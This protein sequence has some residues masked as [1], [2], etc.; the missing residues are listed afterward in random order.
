[1]AHTIG[2][3][4]LT[5]ALC[6]CLAA[7]GV[8]AVLLGQHY[9]EPWAVSAVDA[10]CG[11][12]SQSGCE[13]VA[14]SA[15][16][17]VGGIPLAALGTA[18]YLSLCILLL[19]ILFAPPDLRDVLGGLALIMLVFGLVVDLLLLG[20]QAFSIRAY[21]ILCITTYVLA[22]GALIALLPA[23][24]S[25]HG[26]V[27]APRRP[28]ARLALAG[29]A[30]GTLAVIASAAGFNAMLDSRSAYRE[31][32]LLGTLPATDI[33]EPA[34]PIPA[35]A[36]PVP[37]ASTPEPQKTPDQGAPAAAP[38]TTGSRDADYWQKQ[39]KRLE[40]TLDDPQKFEDYQRAKALQVYETS[41]PVSISLENTPIKGYDFAPVT[42]VE[43]SDFLCIYCRQLAAAFSRFVPESG[44]RVKVYFKNY[45]LD[46][47]CN[48]EL[49]GSTHPGACNL[50]LGG[51]C[52]HRQG[53]FEAYHDHVF[54]AEIEDPQI[55][56]VVKIGVQAGLDAA[57]LQSC[58][59]DPKAKETL[60]AE[61]AEG[62]RLGVRSTPTV[63]VNGKK[64]PRI[65]DFVFVVD[66]EARKKGF[67]PMASE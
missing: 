39:A 38:P 30:I 42:V 62:N 51:I 32:T 15:W 44:G 49:S 6:L 47:S 66:R 37:D 29:W 1:M 50:A 33:A 46:N 31:T 48:D 45:P 56:D 25:I 61:I 40:E 52:A 10:T 36:P 60:A 26:A 12:G 11:E 57:S 28:E 7:A 13:S 8:S 65:S 23:R 19:L 64:L 14:R 18:F 3:I 34:A 2:M 58:L 16:S 20:V 54:S 24:R 21:C 67:K 63:Y 35:P 17:A 53:K 4:R 9:G 59:D 22:A 41:K 43:F 5:L 27:A 55:A